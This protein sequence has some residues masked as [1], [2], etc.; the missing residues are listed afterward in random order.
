MRPRTR[1]SRTVPYVVR[2]N[3]SVH[4]S[5]IMMFF[6]LM[7]IL[8]FPVYMLMAICALSSLIS[9]YFYSLSLYGKLN[10]PLT[11]HSSNYGNNTPSADDIEVTGKILKWVGRCQINKIWFTAYYAFGLFWSSWA[12]WSERSRRAVHI[13]LELSLVWILLLLHLSRRLYECLYVHVWGSSTM[14]I[15]AFFIGLIYYV[16]LPFV[17]IPVN[18]TELNVYP[19]ED[20]SSGF[21]SIPDITAHPRS[22][23]RFETSS[24]LGNVTERRLT[25]L[26]AVGLVIWGQ[27]EQYIHHTLLAELRK[28]RKQRE[29]VPRSAYI[30]KYGLPQG[31]WFRFVSSPHYLSEI[32]IYIGLLTLL[33]CS[34]MHKL[35]AIKREIKLPGSLS[36]HFRNI[37]A[38]G[39]F[40]SFTLKI[41]MYHSSSGFKAS[42]LMLW[43]V[44]NLSI[45]AH[46]NHKWYQREFADYPGNPTMQRKVLIPYIW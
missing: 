37:D 7:N 27:Y 16:M 29:R 13:N 2:D 40:H 19:S 17:F 44:T 9:P 32:I 4:I 30:S 43:I 25:V 14:N 38:E 10:S 28:T 23:T 46:R 22:T 21:N 42:A 3:E 6:Q 39:S 1:T 31:N 12:F 11:I 5:P 8:V 41:L 45:S 26:F 34:A 15:T 24:L 35:Q 18:V 33:R 20:Y 36:N